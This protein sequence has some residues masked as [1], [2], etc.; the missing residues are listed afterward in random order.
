MMKQK[1]KILFIVMLI[2]GL[3]SGMAFR[4][5]TAAPA[6]TALK[7]LVVTGQNNHDWETS[8]PI[9]KQILEDTGLFEVDI[10]STPPRGGDMESFNPDFASYQLVVL[11]YNGDA[12][13]AQTQKAFVDYVKEGGGVVVYHAANN[14]FPGWR[15]YN[16]IIGLGGWG[17]RNETSGPYV[18]WKD[19][20]MV[21]DLSP[22][23]GGHHGYQHDFLVTNRDTTHPITRGLPRK[24]MHA[25]DELYSLLR[26]PAK[27]LHILATA[28]NDPRQGGTGRDE[29]ILFTVKYGKGRIFHTVLGHAGEEI[30][31]PAMECVGFIVTFQRGAEWAASS[32]VTQKIPGDFPATNRDVST[33]SDVRRWQG[34]RPPSLKMILKE[35]AAY[36]Y[37]HDDEILSRLRD[38]IQSHRD[39]PESRLYCEEQLL[40]FL[41]SNATLA[42]K[43]SACRHLRVLGSRMSVP[44]L[45]KMLIQKDTSDMARFALEKIPGASADRAFI[46]GLAKSSGNVRIGIISSLGQRKV[47]DSVA[48]LGKLV[49]DS[50]SATAVAA[51]AALGQIANPEAFGILSKALTRT[52]GLLQIQVAT[53]LLKCAEQFH[54]Q[55]NLKMAADVYKKLLNTKISLPTR[56][57]AMKGMI[58]SA[59]DDAR[60]MI[61]D[62]LKSKEKEMH[63]PAISM[64]RDTFDGSTIQS[65]CAL[66]PDLPATSK[67]QLLPVLSHYKEQAVLQMVINVTKS[68]EEMVRIAALQA[69]KKLGDASCVNLL[70]QCAARA[71]GAERE[72]ARNS[73]WDLK[74]GDID[75]AI[76]INLIRNSDPGLQYELIQS[77]G[78]RRVYGAKSLLFDRARYSNPK[79]RLIA[80]R[81]LKVIA[82][83]SDL[84]RLLNLLL[85]SKSEVEQNEIG[86]TV[87]AVAGRISQQ[88]FRAYSVKIM[89]ESVKEVKG[90]CALYRVLGKIGDNSTLPLIRKALAGENEDIHDAAVRAL[91]DWPNSTPKDDLLQIAGQSTN[92]VHQVLALRAY[93]RMI[94]MDK[95]RSPEGATQALKEALT[96][97]RR[98]E[99]KKIILGTLPQFSCKDALKLAESLLQEEGVKAEARLAVDQIKEKLEKQRS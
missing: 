43:M 11:D 77:I 80:I 68:K 1:I 64:V 97:A 14:A 93:V 70:A 78:K 94:G 15:E 63:I 7:A 20:K 83:P 52:Q 22:G 18:F 81:T 9:L 84:P 41:N 57:A 87:S 69:L 82:A 74:G 73:L 85:A 51:A 39:I 17:N 21:R 88:N 61:L 92:T 46:K 96:L 91:V 6:S 35:A 67:I 50:N 34:F 47:Q 65:V 90:R 23:I 44:V 36:E 86:N 56:Q 60:K 45:E 54:T 12:W 48:A 99:E 24:W 72:A 28:Y 37:G 16:D 13:S 2:F 19:S 33:P 95:Y 75:Q 55:K 62:V 5:M 40:S 79:I 89:L 30:P 29:P 42:A 3:L 25:K 32:K 53:S 98:H 66:L 58:T 76:I 8:S 49:H 26:G 10:A 27:N 4:I 31:S 71:D 38:Y 59:G